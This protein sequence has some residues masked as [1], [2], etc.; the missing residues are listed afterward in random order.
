MSL[1]TLF[2]LATLYQCWFLIFV[3]PRAFGSPEEVDDF[4]Y[5]HCSAWP[6][7]GR[8]SSAQELIEP[9]SSADIAPPV[10]VIIC[11]RNEAERL[12]KYLSLILEQDYPNFEV[13]VVD[14]FSSD[15][16]AKVVADL[17]CSY[18]KLRLVRPEKPTRPGKKDALTF[19]I[20]QARHSILLLTDADCAPVSHHWI[21][22]MA[23]PF[24][25][26]TIELVIGYSPYR[27]RSDWL[28][29]FQRFE[30]TYTAFQY[31]GLARIGLPYMAVGRNVAYRKT[32]FQRAGGLESHAHLAGGDDDLLVS[33]HAR[34]EATAIVT[35]SAARTISDPATD[36]LDY[37][38]RKMRHVGVGVAYPFL[39]K[40]LIGGL[41]LSHL[42]WYGLMFYGVLAGEITPWW[43]GLIVLRLL[44]VCWN[45][46][47]R[48]G[49]ENAGEQTTFFVKVSGVTGIF[50]GDFILCFYYLFTAPALLVGGS[51]G[52]WS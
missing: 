45:Y 20:V 39:P 42:L 6:E 7:E 37:W 44:L 3:F 5:H 46:G 49:K 28:N 16:T 34:S 26:D 1:F 12:A 30:T 2:L 22:E 35:H 21:R 31:L 4:G 18:D 9:D 43:L 15:S 50:L 29:L 38:Q 14:D 52:G 51:K 24:Q 27:R 40:F 23:G 13:V 32:F 19:G 36:W 8:G 11:C 17:Q 25:L 47:F 48:N 33:H 41:A 10:S